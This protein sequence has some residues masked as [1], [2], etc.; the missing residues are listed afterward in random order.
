MT[1]KAPPER[2]LFSPSTE[3]AEIPSRRVRWNTTYRLIPS[4][5]PPIDL[6][7]RVASPE[8]WDA[9]Y[10]LEALTNPRLRDETGDIRLVPISKRVTGPNA[11]VVMAP[12]TH[13]SRDRQ[14][15]FSDGSF[16]IYYAGRAFETA[17]LEVSFHMARFHAATRDPPMLGWYRC[18]K[19]AIDRVMHDIRGGGYE[20]LLRPDPDDY[21]QPQALAT[22]L[23]KSGSNGI[24]YPSVRH[25]GGDCIAAFWP[26]VVTIPTQER[27]LQLKWDG[28]SISTWFDDRDEQWKPLPK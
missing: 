16:G 8:D 28:A 2:D 14:T 19:G 6:F 22:I 9:L 21:V 15:R 5:Y 17:L 11:T 23:R 4:R 18:Y 13:C 7:E 10:Q 27:H 3:A 25:R 20:A 12:F 26:N 1:R 24:V